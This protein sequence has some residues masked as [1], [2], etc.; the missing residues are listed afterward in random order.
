MFIDR[1]RLQ[2]VYMV[3][4]A[5][6]NL[7]RFPVVLLYGSSR[8]DYHSDFA[9]TTTSIFIFGSAS[10]GTPTAVHNGLCGM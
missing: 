6:S 7:K 10:M 3:Y 9:F 5:V 4:L 8:R 1:R 2:A